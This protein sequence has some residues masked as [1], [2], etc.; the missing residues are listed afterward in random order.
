M[1]IFDTALLIGAIV[2]VLL[3]W[4]NPRAVGWV[5]LL[6]L[7]FIA[8]T[9]YWRS[10]W[11]YPAAFGGFCD[12]AVCFVLYFASK[13]RW[14]LWIWRL[15]QASVAVNIFYLSINLGLLRMDFPQDT[16]AS[17]LELLNWLCLLLIGG[18]GILQ[19]IG[20][21]NVTAR[22]PWNRVRH[23]ARLVRETRARNHFLSKAN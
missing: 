23:T 11:P 13:Q 14:E 5:L 9:L 17:L 4:K 16:Y 19:L 6:A 3:N 10:D 15:M 1:S 20:E 7:D 2:A 21:T 18:V 8:S 22:E 12:A